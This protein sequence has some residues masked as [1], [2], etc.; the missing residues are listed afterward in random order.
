[1][2]T[3]SHGWHLWLARHLSTVVP[4]CN[5]L[6]CCVQVLLTL[7]AK[8]LDKIPFFNN[9]HPQFL[10]YLIPNLKL[11]YYAAA[12]F[13]IWQN[14]HSSEMYF[15]AEGVLEVCIHSDQGES[16]GRQLLCPGLTPCLEDSPSCRTVDHHQSWLPWMSLC[17]GTS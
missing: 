11:E 7:H 5:Q 8:L 12:E 13:V 6:R 10:E 15:I 1:M 9:K 17:K 2:V 14:D 4:L 3:C 16:Q